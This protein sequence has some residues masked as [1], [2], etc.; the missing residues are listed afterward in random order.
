M[1]DCPDILKNINFKINS[2]NCYEKKLFYIKNVTTSYMLNST[3]NILMSAGNFVENID[4]FNTSL[5]KFTVQILR[6]LLRNWSKFIYYYVINMRKKCESLQFVF[7]Y[8]NFKYL[9]IFF[10]CTIYVLL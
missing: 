3:S 7:L 1:I 9:Y 5:T 10:L 2:K 8:I 6:K 4:F